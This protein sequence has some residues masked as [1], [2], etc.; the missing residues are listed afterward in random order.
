MSANKNDSIPTLPEG[1]KDRGI[2]RD[3]EGDY[4]H[5]DG[6][7]FRVLT[8]RGFSSDG[9]RIDEKDIEGVEASPLDYSPFER[10]GA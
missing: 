7:R 9:L 3:F 4:W 5:F 8:A 10:V 1:V 2:Y 6:V